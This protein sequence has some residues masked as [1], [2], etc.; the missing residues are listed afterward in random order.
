MRTV[1]S[2]SLG[3]SRRDHEVEAALL[4]ETF[5]IRRVGTDGD[6][7]K[8]QALLAELDGN[9]DA[10]GLG[11]I[12][13]Y[14]YSRRERFALRDGLRL[15]NMVKKTPVV[16]GSGL[17]NSL[18]RQVIRTLA[19][20]RAA[21]I[22]LRGRKTLVV[23]GMDR[24]GMAEAL[25]EAGASVS[26]GDLIFSI[27]KDQLITS[28]DELADYADKLLPEVAKMPISFIY[29]TGKQQDKAPE[30]KHTRYY[31]DAEIVAGD[32]HFIRKFMPARMDGKVVITNT[33]TS[34]DLAELKRRGASWLVATTP[35]FE[36]R[37]FGTNV[38][39]AA[40]LVLLGKAWADVT[41]DD[42]LALID[43]LGLQP[44]VVSLNP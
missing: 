29:P 32:F 34:D 27:G 31:D 40:L 7:R 15:M 43:R 24:F 44:R 6:F 41:P 22:P 33:V 20:T 17:K 4:G 18:E 13:V 42:Y 16:D 26:Y 30:E 35:E 38:L 10:I 28:L 3:S 5:R 11:G 9:V 2:V 25:E 1:V 23:C 12:D 8:A 19:A 37:S 39:E 21:E 14:L 36:G